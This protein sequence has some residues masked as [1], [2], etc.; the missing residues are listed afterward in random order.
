[1]GLFGEADLDALAARGCQ[2]CGR[3]KLA[4]RTYVDARIPIFAGEPDGALTWVYDGEK[5]VDGIFEITCAECKAAV[6]SADVCPRCNGAGGLRKALAAGNAFEVPKAC[7]GC[8]REELRYYAMLPAKVIY[9]G[10][11]ADK[12]RTVTDLWDPGCHGYRADCAACGPIA[13]HDDTC[14]LCAAPGP[15]RPRP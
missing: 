12:P 5:F 11:R 8:E 10:K 2:A 4:F 9:E 3:N 6:F 1:M 13:T 14:P 7:P 15:L